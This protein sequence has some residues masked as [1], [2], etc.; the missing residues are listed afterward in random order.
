VK[1]IPN[2]LIEQF[3]NEG[4]GWAAPLVEVL[5]DFEV[6]LQL[7]ESD[8]GDRSAKGSGKVTPAFRTSGPVKKRTH[9]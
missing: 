1:S 8:T 7:L 9:K 4:H 6:R 2:P 3:R 5:E